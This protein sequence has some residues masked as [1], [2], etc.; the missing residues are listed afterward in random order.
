M[1]EEF[2]QSQPQMGF[3]ASGPPAESTCD[4]PSCGGQDQRGACR[5]QFACGIPVGVVSLWDRGRRSLLSGVAWMVAYVL[6]AIIPCFLLIG[7]GATLQA[8]ADLAASAADLTT[9]Y[10]SLVRLAKGA[11]S[12]EIALAAETLRDRGV[13]DADE[14]A[15]LMKRTKGIDGEP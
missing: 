8:N 13:L 12:E 4:A 10:E 11:P 7:M 14:F 9:M 2:A 3:A 6:L 15:E 5:T 1:S